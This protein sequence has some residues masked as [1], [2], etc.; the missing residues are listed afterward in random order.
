M[1]TIITRSASY[2]LS[3]PG[4]ENTDFFCSQQKEV[5]DSEAEKTSEELYAFCYKEVLKSIRA[6]TKKYNK[7]LEA[8]K[9]T[10][11]RTIEIMEERFDPEDF[12]SE[13]VEI[14]NEP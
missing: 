7:A 4:Y 12:V 1:K 6:F 10:Q 14:I 3:L 9:N 13:E 11:A 8:K 2:K 5:E